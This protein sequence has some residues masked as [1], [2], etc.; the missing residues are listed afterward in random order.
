VS[1][2]AEEGQ[3]QDSMRLNVA[4]SPATSTT[5][6]RSVSRQ[7]LDSQYVTDA[8]LAASLLLRVG[9]PGRFLMLQS[10]RRAIAL[11]QVPVQALAT[12][13]SVLAFGWLLVND[14]VQP[15]VIILLELF[16]TF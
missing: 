10:I 2:L 7:I 16:L 1:F 8:E 12:V 11:P 14:L 9:E 5:G 3:N 15:I 6:K 13:V 4:V